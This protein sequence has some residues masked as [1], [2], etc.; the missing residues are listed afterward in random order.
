MASSVSIKNSDLR[1]PLGIPNASSF[2]GQKLAKTSIL[3][4]GMSSLGSNTLNQREGINI[5]ATAITNS[6]YN[7]SVYGL[8]GNQFGIQPMPGINSVQIDSK[9]RG[10]IRN[11]TVEVT[12]FNRFQFEIIETLYL[13]LGFTMLIE[14][15]W[16]KY[17][18]NNGKLQ[19]TGTTFTENGFFSSSN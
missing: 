9:N 4:N 5:G 12:A 2:S 8:G 15:G 17:L 18:D 3:F 10:S 14:W 16:D 7:N 11:A 1:V 19:K 13:R 6:D